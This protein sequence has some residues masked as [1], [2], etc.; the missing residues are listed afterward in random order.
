MTIAFDSVQILDDLKRVGPADLAKN[1]TDQETDLKQELVSLVNANYKEF[2]AVS[3]EVKSV[4]ASISSLRPIVD[5]RT[6]G[7]A[8]ERVR[9]H[10]TST[11]TESDKLHKE[12][13]DIDR[14]HADFS[15]LSEIIDIL[16]DV[17]SSISHNTIVSTED[18][19]L[20]VEEFTR[21]TIMID[22]LDCVISETGISS[23]SLRRALP[24]VREECVSIRTCVSSFLT[25]RF[26]S[27]ELVDDMVT[28]CESFD[29]LNMRET[30]YTIL[31][32]KYCSSLPL[33]FTDLP[34]SFSKIL[35]TYIAPS[36]DH[37]FRVLTERLSFPLRV[38]VL[39]RSVLDQLIK[40][41]PASVF[42]PGNMNEARDF[43]A[44]FSAYQ[45]FLTRT[46]TPVSV[47]TS[48]TR[49]W[50]VQIYA[51]VVLKDI[52]T[53]LV[54][55]KIEL[56][57]EMESE[58]TQIIALCPVRVYQW[59]SGIC[60]AIRNGATHPDLVET[61]VESA[62]AMSKIG[63]FD[64][65]FSQIESQLFIKRANQI[66]DSLVTELSSSVLPI[67]ESVKQIAALYRAAASRAG[68]HSVY[69]DLAA[70]PI[71]VFIS[72]YFTSPPTPASS[73]LL[74]LIQSRFLAACLS[75]FDKVADEMLKK[76]KNELIAN[77]VKLDREKINEIF[78]TKFNI[79]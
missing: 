15:E 12:L 45:E 73:W 17:S 19:P 23:D 5:L 48:Y 32:A 39:V 8:F 58:F 46:S 64:A 77:Q 24:L 69:V 65:K 44:N 25:N 30:L 52:D 33:S 70:K 7:G 56:I 28:L 57:S 37:V 60:D 76:E 50:Q 61:C 49:K 63:F 10:L 72:K 74:S 29:M 34:G 20:I 78:S 31:Q 9:M 4:A 42:V 18:I 14:T 66:I 51:R 43:F 71:S 75:H 40:T 53:R 35:D 2:L 26:Q 22:A 13:R 27:T 3:N 54:G 59:L 36:S 21:A 38:E 79:S 55:R 62:H 68:R 67:I 16:T 47:S 1:L 11:C 6:S 41:A